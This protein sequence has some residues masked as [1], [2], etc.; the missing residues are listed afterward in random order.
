MYQ[1]NQDEADF[2]VLINEYAPLVRRLAEQVRQKN[3]SGLDLDDLIQSGIVGLLHARQT[4]RDDR[5]ASFKT[6][7]VMQIRFS[8]FDWLRKQSGITR[9]VSQH[10]KKIAAAI[11]QIEQSNSAVRNTSIADTLGVS[12]AK[13][14]NM[15]EEINAYKTVSS[16]DVTGD[17]MFTTDPDENPMI[18][19]LQGEMRTG[20]KAIISV[21]PK[22][23]Q[24]ILALYYTEFLSLKEIGDVIGLTEA[25]V[26]QLHRQLLDKLKS[27]MTQ[28]E[29]ALC[30]V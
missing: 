18:Q 12:D 13:Y 14:V 17:L 6:Y 8:I 7:A 30:D 4:Y 27:R 21:L 26:S 5:G 1:P 16:E 25:R 29:D 3:P 23:E 20:I 22:R 15:V 9:D 19:A 2:A 28:F 24:L 10:I 11:A